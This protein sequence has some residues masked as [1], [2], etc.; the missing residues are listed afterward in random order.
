MAPFRTL[1]AAALLFLSA[2]N[3][4]FVL[5]NPVSLEGDNLDDEKEGNAPCGALVPDLSQKTTNTFHADGDFISLR[6]GHPQVNWLFRGTLTDKAA[7]NWTQLFP[8]VTQSGLGNF[9]EPSVAV[10]KDWVGKTGIIGAVA[11]GPDGILYQVCVPT[12]PLSQFWSDG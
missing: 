2:A 5:L 4:H 6:S 7:G 1:T 11:K 12:G 10:P 3:A 8:I 9:C